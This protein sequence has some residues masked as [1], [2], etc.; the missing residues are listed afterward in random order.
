MAFYGDPDELD[1][2][3]GQIETRAEEV[4][5]RATEMDAKARAM[6]WKSIAADRCRE[7]IGED[8]RALHGVAERMDE[9]AAA[10]R[11]HAQEVRELLAMIKNAM[12]KITGWFRS[13]VDTFNRAVEGFKDAVKDI[14][15]GIGDALGFGGGDAPKPPQPPWQ[16]WKWGPD[17]LPPEDDKAWL[18]VDEYLRQQGVAA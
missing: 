18:E 8:K 3:A 1:R 6:H 4:R 15:D 17:N 13:A 11:R 10:L 2:I 9:A 7:L 12:E 5:T 14:A 16:G